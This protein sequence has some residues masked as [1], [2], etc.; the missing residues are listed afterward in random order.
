MLVKSGVYDERVT[1][2]SGSH[3]APA[4]VITFRDQPRRSVTMWGSYTRYA[5]YPRI[6]GF[7]ITTDPS[8]TGWMERNGVF[9][10]SDHVEVIDNYLYDLGSTAIS[11]TSVGAIVA[12]NRIY[13]SQ[14][15]LAIS[16]SDWLV[17]GDEVERLYDYGGGDC[18]YSRIFGDNHVIRSNVFHGTLFSETGA[19]HVDCF[20][21]FDNHGEYAPALTLWHRPAWQTIA[22]SWSV[23]V[24]LPLTASWTIDYAGPPGDQ[25]PPI[26]GIPGGTRTYV[27]TGLTNYAWYTITLSTNPPLVTGTL[28]AMPTDHVV[29][30][31]VVRR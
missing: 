15:G 13:R 3:G 8:L 24:T 27:L 28:T 20:Q 10:A 14:A 1:F 7:N 22:L 9:I 4:Q 29:Y 26:T 18:D 11:G 12:D 5:H 23:N 31:A 17:E 30:L 21:T 25:A 19:A 6:E 2:S 16:G